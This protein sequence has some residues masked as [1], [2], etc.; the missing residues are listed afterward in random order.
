M[1]NEAD[2]FRSSPLIDIIEQ[3]AKYD[4]H[5]LIYEPLLTSADRDIQGELV[6]FSTLS[7]NS[8]II[9]ANRYHPE[10]ES[11]RDKVYTRD[12]F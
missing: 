3:L 8:D 9:I 6:D 10:L 11:V 5:I 2:N 7:T 1:K 12:L 4:V